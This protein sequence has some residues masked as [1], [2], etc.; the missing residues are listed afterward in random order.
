MKIRTRKLIGTIATVL[1]LLIYCLI[2]MAVGGRMVVGYGIV[3]EL[4]FYIIAGIAWLPIE[5]IIIKWMSKPD[6][7]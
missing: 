5:M 1:Y 7:D 3:A 6:S 2:A 4:P